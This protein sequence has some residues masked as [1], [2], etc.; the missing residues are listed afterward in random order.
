MDD[1]HKAVSTPA[2]ATILKKDL[3]TK[4]CRGRF[5][6]TNWTCFSKQFLRTVKE[7][8]VGNS[9]SLTSNKSPL[10]RVLGFE[11]KPGKD[12]LLVETNEFETIDKND[13]TQRNY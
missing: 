4:F 12:L 13:L 5:N 3:Q 8:N 10:E 6:L 7:N 11:R 9:D 2:E 1:P